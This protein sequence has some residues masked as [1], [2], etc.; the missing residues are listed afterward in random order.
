MSR[1]KSFT[2]VLTFF[3]LLFILA[4]VARAE[5]T[6]AILYLT[7][8]KGNGAEIGAV[9]FVDEAD[10]LS[11]SVNLKG[12][13]PGKHGFH[14]H[15]HPDCGPMEKDG[16]IGHALAAGGHYDPEKTGK[17]LGPEGGGHK[18][19]LPVLEVGADGSVVTILKVKGVQAADFKYRSVMIHAGGDNYSDEPLPLGGGGARI[20]CGIIR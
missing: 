19:D 4:T 20:A 10:A 7:T 17:H 1:L 8:D 3:S 5:N 9:T 15:E 11:V 13:P 6:S 2:S 18:G 16:V 14:V 12:L